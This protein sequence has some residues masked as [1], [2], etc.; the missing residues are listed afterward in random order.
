[1]VDENRVARVARALCVADGNDPEEHIYVGGRETV[2]VDGPNEYRET[3]GSAWVAYLAEAH[4]MVVAVKAM[5]L[6]G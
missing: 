4:R 6:L 3:M 5:G 2:E 1:M